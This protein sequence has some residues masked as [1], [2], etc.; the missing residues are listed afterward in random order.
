[1][2]RSYMARLFASDTISH[3]FHAHSTISLAKLHT[4][5]LLGGECEDKG[6]G[7]GGRSGSDMTRHDTHACS[8]ELKIRSEK[9]RI[10]TED[11]KKTFAI[12]SPPRKA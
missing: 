4:D 1:M 10:I 2:T 3:S 8:G 6:G 12:V 5:N 9:R 11:A 7:G